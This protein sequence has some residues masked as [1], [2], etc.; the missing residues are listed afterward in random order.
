MG[1]RY[2]NPS[3]SIGFKLVTDEIDKKGKTRNVNPLDIE[4]YEVLCSLPASANIT[5]FIKTSIVEYSKLLDKDNFS[6]EI[7]LDIVHMDDVIHELDL[8]KLRLDKIE[9]ELTQR[10]QNPGDIR[11]SNSKNDN[12]RHNKPLAQNKRKNKPGT[13]TNSKED[14][15]S[16]LNPSENTPESAQEGN[17]K[18]PN[19][20]KSQNEIKQKIEDKKIQ[21]DSDME[22]EQESDKSQEELT[23]TAELVAE[24]W[25]KQI[26]M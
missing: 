21:A 10:D 9:S 6:S 4:V 7:K 2:K 14:P 23:P 16:S 11:K 15:T 12:N 24:E 8:C 1:R 22:P 18:Y 25:L 20:S 17:Y 26:G 13:N 19:E 5:Q 3:K